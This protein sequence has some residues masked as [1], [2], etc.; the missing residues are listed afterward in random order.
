[1]PQTRSADPE[2]SYYQTIEELEE[3]RRKGIP[4]IGIGENTTIRHAIIDKNARIGANVRILNE[5][6]VEH[7]D[8]DDYYIREGIVIVP[9]GATIADGT[10]I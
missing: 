4:W 1:M 5:A 10:V 6:G 3:E 9:K 2:A 7:F 8:G